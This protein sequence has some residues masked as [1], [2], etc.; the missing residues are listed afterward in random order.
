MNYPKVTTDKMLGKMKSRCDGQLFG[1]P[2]QP[3]LLNTFDHLFSSTSRRPHKKDL[4][5]L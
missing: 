1:P 5:K 3:L 2:G 4:R